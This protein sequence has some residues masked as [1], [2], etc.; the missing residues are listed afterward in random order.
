[1]CGLIG[2]IS[3]S[4]LV[5]RARWQEACRIQGHRGPDDQGEIFHPLPGRDLWFAHQRLS[6]IDLSD[7]A[8]QPIGDPAT[9]G[10]LVFNGE[11][12]N[13]LEL[14]SDLE[15]QGRRIP[16]TGD[17]VVLLHALAHWGLDE[18]VRR[19]N[20]M[21]AFAWVEPGSRRL[22]LSRDRAGEKPLYW[23]RDGQGL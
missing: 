2:A 6:I 7:A 8:H 10:L 20:G 3:P 1:M 11:I 13:Y 4:G 18:T 9:T 5:D 14:R 19:L 15:A 21:W 17:T 12:Y 22:W 16:S 23:T